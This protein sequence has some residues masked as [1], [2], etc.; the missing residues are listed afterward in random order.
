MLIGGMER[1]GPNEPQM[2]YAAPVEIYFLIIVS[3]KSLQAKNCHSSKWV[4]GKKASKQK[5]A[6]FHSL[7]VEDILTGYID[8][9]MIIVVDLL[10]NV[11]VIRRQAMDTIQKTCSEIN[12]NSGVDLA[13]CR[14]HNIKELVNKC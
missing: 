4:S 12:R 9:S 6:T 8:S 5:R 14:K 10:P 7:H 11:L 2:N 1:D 13:N 3:R